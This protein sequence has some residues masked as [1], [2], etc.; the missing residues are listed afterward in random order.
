LEKNS[1]DIGIVSP[2]SQ[3][4]NC[5]Y[6]TINSKALEIKTIDSFQGREKSVIILSTVRSRFYGERM[7][8]NK[9]KTIGF[10]GDM[11]RINV[12]LSRAKDHCIIVGDLK[13]LSIN[14]AWKE[15]IYEAMENDQV[16][17]VKDWNKATIAS[18]FKNKQKNL[19]KSFGIE[20]N[21]SQQSK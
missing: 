10:V 17:E 8:A 11:R 5:I 18:I 4:V 3:Q 6:G 9:K 7:N 20:R 2:Y 21:P 1:K 15:I 19:I 13:R 12:S 14:K 16:Y